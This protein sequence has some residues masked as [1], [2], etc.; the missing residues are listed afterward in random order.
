ML[1]DGGE[2]D[3]VFDKNLGAKVDRLPR[4]VPRDGETDFFP[5]VFWITNPSNTYTGNVAAGSQGPGFWFELKLRAPSSELEINHGINPKVLPQKTFKDNAAHSS[6]FRAGFT[7][8][9]TGYQAPIGTVWENIKAYKNNEVGL[10]QHGTSHI[11]FQGG[12][13]ADNGQ[14]AHNF[15]HDNAIYDGVEVI[16]RSQHMQFLIDQGRIAD[17]CKVGGLSLQPNEGMGRGTTIKNSSFKGFN[18]GCSGGPRY[19]IHVGNNQVRNGVF[20]ASPT[21]F[22][23]TFDDE[24]VSS[25]ISACMGIN[26]SGDNDVRNVVIE[27]EDGS[28]S[29]ISAGFFVQDVMAVTSFVDTT[30]CQPVEPIEES[31]L[32]FCETICLRLGI[33]SISQ[34][35][36]TRGFQMHISDGTN[37]AAVNRGKIWFDEKQNHLSAPMPLALPAAATG[38]PYQI[39]FTDANGELA[40]PGYA[41]LNLE[42][43]PS[44]IGG[45]SAEEIEFV[46]P[47]G[48]GD[49]CEDL[50]KYDD[51]PQAIHGW[52]NFFSGLVVSEDADKYVISTTRR[53]D[54]RGH[55]N[56]SRNLDTSCLVGNI[57][58]TFHLFGK[59][60]MKDATGNDVAS[61]GNSNASPKITFSINGGSS[62]FV[63]TWNLATYSDG[64]WAEFSEQI[65]MPSGLVGATRAQIIIDKAEKQEF[66]ITEWGMNLIPSES[67]TLS[68][69]EHPTATPTLRPSSQPTI[70]LEPSTLT[71]T[72]EPVTS[73][74]V[75]ATPTNLALTGLASGDSECYNG[76]AYKA[77]DGDLASINHSCCNKNGA[78]LMVDLGL[79]ALNYIQKIVVKNRQDCCG[80]RLKLFHVELLD[81]DKNV[82]FTQYHGAHVGNAQER[83]FIVDDGTAARFAR[84]RYDDSHKDCL[85][86]AELEVWGYPI[87]LPA[88]QDPIIGK[89]L[90]ELFD[91]ILLHCHTIAHDCVSIFTI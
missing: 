50:F 7:T 33:V 5:S 64:N 74:P 60:R 73:A 22:N 55:V 24:P 12:L 1:E 47:D 58:R 49:R 8:Y 10:F 18:N 28:I 27:D 4:G 2:W 13:L 69:S 19:A 90:N 83:E 71:P 31:C 80:G 54:D 86:V 41:N 15:H 70:S 84:I 37:T 63:K 17:N 81:A 14:A 77:I 78:W 85:H 75:S 59:M 30:K 29:G 23:N 20:D 89:F 25:R 34:D 82:V 6:G 56:L 39:T 36:T 57:G 68:P 43:A 61:D 32:L 66:F 91:L 65:T 53:K 46:M 72:K 35:L 48:G 52:Q 9:E 79:G 26:S 67:P 21:I 88:S 76:F 62:N 40:W 11:N 45:V 16:G 42:R 3:N 44:C 87:V 38:S 51:Y